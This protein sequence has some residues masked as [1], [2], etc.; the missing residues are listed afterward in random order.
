MSVRACL[1]SSPR[2]RW[3]FRDKSKIVV[4]EN[5]RRRLGMLAKFAA[6]QSDFRFKQ[7]DLVHA[8]LRFNEK[9]CPPSMRM[10]NHPLTTPGAVGPSRFPR[11]PSD[12]ARQ[13]SRPKP[14]SP[15]VVGARCHR[16]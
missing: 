6:L 12:S 11:A 13:P 4:E 1:R 7:A 3:E 16:R 5:I 2:F 10:Q 14:A 8:V 9:V 15:C